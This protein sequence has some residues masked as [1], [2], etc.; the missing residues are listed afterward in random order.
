MLITLAFTSPS[1]FYLCLAVILIAL[2][3]HCWGPVDRPTE[4]VLQLLPYLMT[5]TQQKPDLF[6]TSEM[7]V[8]ATL[9]ESATLDRQL[10]A[11]TQKA[12]VL[13]MALEGMLVSPLLPDC[14]LHMNWELK[15]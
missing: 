8:M 13:E 6:I 10:R 5:L 9:E 7:A 15:L 1:H 12:A 14:K 11:G 2:L 3:I 4:W